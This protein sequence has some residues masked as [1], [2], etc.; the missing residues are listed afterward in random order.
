MTSDSNT[1]P[2]QNSRI[3]GTLSSDVTNITIIISDVDPVNINVTSGETVTKTIGG[4]P[5]GD[6]TVLIDLKNAEGII[7]YT[8]TQTIAV[9][10][11]ETASPTFPANDFTAENVEIELIS[12]N[13]GEDWELGSTQDITWTTSHSAENVSITLYSNNTSYQVLSAET[14][15]TGSYSWTIADTIA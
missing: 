4:V 2:G 7:L 3:T 6:Q 11:G 10:A 8:Q 9:E 5:V 14:A 15:S 1:N 12:P 13:G